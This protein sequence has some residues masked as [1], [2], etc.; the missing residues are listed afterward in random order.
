MDV[1]EAVPFPPILASSLAAATL[2]NEVLY[3][4]VSLTTPDDVFI[5]FQRSC[6]SVDL[7]APSST[8]RDRVADP[9]TRC[10]RQ[11]KAGADE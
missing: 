9:A 1:M 3:S 10:S 7:F 8:Y 2:L 11:T 6:S 5:P 4:N